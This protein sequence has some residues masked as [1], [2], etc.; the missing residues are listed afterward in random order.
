MKNTEKNLCL[1]KNLIPS[2][3]VCTRQRKWVSIHHQTERAAP[4][5]PLLQTGLW[6]GEVK[7]GPG[8]QPERPE[9][10]AAEAA[11]ENGAVPGI[12]GEPPDSHTPSA[13]PADSRTGR[14]KQ[15]EH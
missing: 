11:D 1:Q 7:V 9:E 6:S 10:G 15:E 4:R 3:V 8:D 12:Q 14:D 5:V 2:S 13:G